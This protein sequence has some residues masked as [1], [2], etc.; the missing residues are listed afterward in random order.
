MNYGNGT[1][2]LITS[3]TYIAGGHFLLAEL[4]T[5]G[6]VAA[7]AVLGRPVFGGYGHK[8]HLAQRWEGLPPEPKTLQAFCNKEH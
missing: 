4:A 3:L 7:V 8:A 5:G 2:V 1:V 6:E